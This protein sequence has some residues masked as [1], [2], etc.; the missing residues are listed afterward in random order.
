M[1]ASSTASTRLREDVQ[2]TVDKRILVL[3][4][5]ADTLFALQLRR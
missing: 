1:L 5:E 4:S 3:I 2:E